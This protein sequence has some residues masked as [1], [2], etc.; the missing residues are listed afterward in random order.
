[1]SDGNRRDGEGGNFAGNGLRFRDGSVRPGEEP[2][3]GQYDF[4]MR[5]SDAH[6]LAPE[7]EYGL[8]RPSYPIGR[9]MPRDADDRLYQFGEPNRAY[10]TGGDGRQDDPTGTIQERSKTAERFE[11]TGSEGNREAMRKESDKKARK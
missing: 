4:E 8:R 2:R 7:M 5:G 10:R 1:M 6:R 3:E 11:P 9:P